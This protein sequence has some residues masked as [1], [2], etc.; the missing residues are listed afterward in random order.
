MRRLY[1]NSNHAHPVLTKVL[2]HGRHLLTN[3]KISDAGATTIAQ[4]LHHNSTLRKLD[5]SN[6]SIT[7]A[8]VTPVA[9]ALHH[10][11]NLRELDL[12]NNSITDAGATA[13]AQAL[14]HSLHR[15]SWLG[16]FNLSGNDSIH[17]KKVLAH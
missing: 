14:H 8:G 7:D 2:H 5:L 11:S 4:A 10:N 6:N 3:K 9:Q 17:K 1:F 16:G 15:E 12:S 13:L